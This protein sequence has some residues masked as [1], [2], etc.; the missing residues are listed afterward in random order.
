MTPELIDALERQGYREL[1][2]VPG[3][4]VCGVMPMLF[5]VGLFHGITEHG[6]AARYCYPLESALEMIVA[7]HSWD[8]T[9]HPSGNWIKHKGDGVDET[10]PNA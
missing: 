8:G 2:E 3:R 6:Y 7:L 1:R 10:N 5:T 4:G 9:G